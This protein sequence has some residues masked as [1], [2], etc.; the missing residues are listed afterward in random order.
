MMNRCLLITG[1][2]KGNGKYVHLDD[3]SLTYFQRCIDHMYEK[4][5]D[6]PESRVWFASKNLMPCRMH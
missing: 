1:T 5:S 3:L 6:V 4:V 2:E